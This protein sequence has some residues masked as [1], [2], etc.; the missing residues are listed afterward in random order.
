M[1]AVDAAGEPIGKAVEALLDCAS[2]RIAYVVIAS[3]G[4]AGARETLRAI[5]LADLRF[6]DDGL[7][8]AGNSE[9]FERLEPIEGDDW[10]VGPPAS[11]AMD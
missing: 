2:G 11:K 1:R 10:P 4:L 6:A 9:A 7:R 5:P 3:G 8:F